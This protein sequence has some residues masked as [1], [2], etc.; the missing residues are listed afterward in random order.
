MKC[1]IKSVVG[2][3][4]G[5]KNHEICELNWDGENTLTKSIK[6]DS[7][8]LN[9]FFDRYPKPAEVRVAMECGTSSPWIS[10][11]LK[12][13]G[14]QVYVGNPRKMRAI[15]DTDNKTDE[16][17]AEMIARIA[18]FDLKLLYPIKHR[19]KE[20]QMDLA[21]LKARDGIVRNRTALINEIRGICKSAG[22]GLPKCSADSFAS[23]SKDFI[24]KGL[25]PAL[26]P[27]IMMID[28]QT[29]LLRH[30]DK[31]IGEECEKY[32]ETKA[33]RKIA[34]VGPLTA[35]GFILTLEEPS[36]FAKSRDVGPY[37]GLVPKRDKSGEMDKPLGITKAGNGYQRRLLVGAAQYILGAFG[38]PCDLRRYGE[39]IAGDGKNKIRKRKAVVAVARKLAVLLH[40]LWKTG[41][42]YDPDYKINRKQLKKAS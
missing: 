42:E 35:L 16:R 7:G 34:G 33:L 14:F 6:N 17:D 2:L 3:D 40:H 23:K 9:R 30:Y 20:A 11:I 24:P 12:T 27:L 13:R 29:K 22:T 32:S 36:R 25:Q 26:L 21:V 1:N 39:R 41:D 37:L 31:L 15:W 4:L 19:S 10:D 38:P 28:A 5:D 8:S 18:R